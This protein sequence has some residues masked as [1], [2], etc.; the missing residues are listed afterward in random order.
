MQAGLRPCCSQTSEDWFSRVE[1]HV[2]FDVLINIAAMLGL[3]H[4]ILLLAHRLKYNNPKELTRS[5]DTCTNL[6]GDQ[7]ICFLRDTN[8][9]PFFKIN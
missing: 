2:I 6:K 4:V 7:A 1:A 5:L 9:N 8:F 3:L